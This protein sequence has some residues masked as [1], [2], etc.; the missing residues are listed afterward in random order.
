MFGTTARTRKIKPEIEVADKRTDTSHS[1]Q[2]VNQVRDLLFVV[3]DL[4]R[5]FVELRIPLF[6]GLR[7]VR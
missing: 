3:F 4:L 5:C 2:I 1:I 6:N 7:I